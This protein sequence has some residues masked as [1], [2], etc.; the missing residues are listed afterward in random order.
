MSRLHSK[1]TAG[2]PEWQAHIPSL[3]DLPETDEIRLAWTAHIK[4]C[5]ACASVLAE[6]A[7]FKA[8]MNELPDPGPAYIA[9]RIKEHI[10]KGRSRMTVF[11]P[12]DLIWGTLGSVAGVIL[13]L[14]LAGANLHSS[15]I[16]PGAVF[17]LA[18]TGIGS[19]TNE[20]LTV[21][22]ELQENEP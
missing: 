15:K 16:S 18:L 8:R 14:W 12:V 9:V 10:T 6:E 11:R 3:Q 2:C 17:E 22:A 13:G 21:A 4:D 20:L 19:E 5:A 1:S 7:W